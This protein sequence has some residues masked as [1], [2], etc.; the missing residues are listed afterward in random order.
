MFLLKEK[1]YNDNDREYWNHNKFSF[2]QIITKN[3]KRESV[4][5]YWHL[6][7]GGDIN[8]LHSNRE[9]TK[10]LEDLWLGEMKVESSSL[11][12]NTTTGFGSISQYKL[13]N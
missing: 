10:T 7:K 3:T 12:N 11:R 9:P 6:G 8:C 13:N 4:A 2:T 5:S 1:K